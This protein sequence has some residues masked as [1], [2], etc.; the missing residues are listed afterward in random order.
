MKK[1]TKM[2]YASLSKE[3]KLAVEKQV[4]LAK[5]FIGKNL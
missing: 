5:K 4:D 2:L 1:H 3:L